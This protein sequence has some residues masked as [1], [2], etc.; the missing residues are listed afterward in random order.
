MSMEYLDFLQEFRCS[1]C[2]TFFFRKFILSCV[3]SVIFMC[4]TDAFVSCPV[5]S[6]LSVS[7]HLFFQFF[8]FF[9]FYFFFTFFPHQAI[10]GIKLSKQCQEEL[11][12]HSNSSNTP[13]VFVYTDI[14][15]REK[16]KHMDIVSFAEG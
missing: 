6:I 14:Q 5:L 15:I 13:F 7:I 10:S 4:F 11:Q 9:H 8:A 12:N 2:V 1:N 3:N 16:V